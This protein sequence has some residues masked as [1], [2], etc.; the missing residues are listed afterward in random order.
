MNDPDGARQRPAPAG[1]FPP[2]PVVLAVVA[3][4]ALSF[5]AFV[6]IRQNEHQRVAAEFARRVDQQ[7]SLLHEK[8]NVYEEMFLALRNFQIYAEPVDREEFRGMAGDYLV[9]HP[10]IRALHWAPYVSAAQRA[11]VESAVRA[12]GFPNFEFSERA[13]DGGLARAAVRADY[14]PSIFVEPMNGNESALGFD[15]AS[16]PLRL[17]LLNQARDSGEIV[18][19]GRIRM[20]PQPGEDRLLVVVPVY[21]HNPAPATVALRRQILAGFVIGIFHI[22]PMVE[23]ALARVPTTGLDLLLLDNSAP[24]AGRVLHY[25]ASLG[26]GSWTGS[27]PDEAVLRKGL[28]RET[29]M[30]VGNRKWSFLFRPAPEWLAAQTTLNSYGALISGLSFSLLLSAYL[31]AAARR[32]ETVATQVTQRTA[33]LRE[34]N[35]H[36]ETESRQRQ[37]A[38]RAS[39]KAAVLLRATLE[40]TGDG[41]LVVGPEGRIE[42]YNEK[43]CR[44]WGIAESILT[45]GNDGQAQ[46][47]VLQLLKEPEAFLAKVRE[48]YAQTDAVSLD[49]LGLGVTLKNSPVLELQNI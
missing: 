13:A 20:D 30:Q 27:P 4:C 15:L 34:A 32:A 39:E 3:G 49:D 1:T 42:G 14:V 33:E 5:M 24:A 17:A 35:I 23:T 19:T 31:L 9:R 7:T 48:L 2:L 41:I 22:Q 12:N 40:S 36:L 26:A 16:D 44:M 21:H 37:Q 8:M 6:Q 29:Q 18:A 11:V 46:K 25:H 38:T 28:H 10:E 43:F 47:Q 45:A